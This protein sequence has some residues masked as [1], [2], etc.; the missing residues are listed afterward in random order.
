MQQK[1]AQEETE[2]QQLELQM[3]ETVMNE[4]FRLREIIAQEEGEDDDIRSVTSEQSSNSK[5]RQW[6]AFNSTMVASTEQAPPIDPTGNEATSAIGTTPVRHGSNQ[7]PPSNQGVLEDAMTGISLGQSGSEPTLGGI[8]GRTES[9]IVAT[10]G[11]NKTGLPPPPPAPSGT[12]FKTHLEQF[13]SHSLPTPPVPSVDIRV[14]FS[15]TSANVP[16]NNPAVVSQIANSCSRFAAQS[17]VLHEVGQT[18][19][20]RN[21]GMSVA[22]LLGGPPRLSFSA[23]PGPEQLGDQTVLQRGQLE[24]PYSSAIQPPLEHPPPHHGLAY[25]GPSPQQL[26]ARHVMAKELPTFSG[27]PEDWPL[28]ISAY[29]NS[30]QACGFTD[31]ENL[32]RLQRCLKGHALDSVRSRLLLPAGVPHVLA[33][34]ETLYGRPELLIHALLQKIRGVPPPKQDRLDT[35]IGFGMAVQNLSD[36][37][38]AGRH[39]AHLNNP[40]L[41]FELVEKLPA[42]MKLDWSL[43]KQR[44]AEVNIRSFAQYMQTL[45]RAATDVTLQYDPTQQLS[46]QLQRSSKERFGKDKNFCGTHTSENSTPISQAAEAVRGAS[47]SSNPTCLICKDPEHRVRDCSEFRK[48][49]VEERWKTIQQLSLCRLCLGA[50]GRRPCKIRK[51]CDIGGCQRRHHPLLHSDEEQ[52]DTRRAEDGK[53][54]KRDSKLPGNNVVANRNEV[55]QESAEPKPSDSKVSTNHHFA[56]KTTLFRIIPVTLHGNNRSVSVYAFLDDGS[57]KTLVD[58]EVVKQLGVIGESQPLCLQWTS[59]VKRTEAGS[60][61]VTLE[62]AGFSSSTKHTLSDVRTVNKLDLPRQ[63]LRYAE[64]VKTF[65][66]LRG[67]PVGDY[68]NAQPRILIGN[69]N[70]HVTSTLKLR[71]GQ[72]GEPIAAKSRLGWTVYGS[73][74]EKSVDRVHTFHLCECQ[75]TDQTLHERVEQFFSVDSLGIMEVDRPESVEIQRAN[76]ILRETTKRIGLRFETGLLWKYDCFE[77]PD[78]YHMAVRR[79]Q[80]LERRMQNDPVIGESVRRQLSEYQSKGYI[81]K[82]TQ[83]EL[84]DSDPRRTWYLPLGVVIN[85]KKP[86]KI[87]IFCDAAAKVDGISLN[88]MLLKGPD[89]LRTLLDVLFG[90]RERRIA[91]CAD[92]K[93]M[94]HQIRIRPEDRQAQRL[95]WREDPSQDPEVYLM[96]V[97]TFGATCSPCSAHFVKNLNAEEHAKEFPAAADAIIRKHYVDDYLDSADNVE[98]AVKLANEVKYVHSLGGFHLRNWLSNSREVLAR[99][100]ET[101]QAT[102]KCLQLEKSTTT[103]RVLGMYWKPDEDIFMFS[104]IPALNTKHPTKRQALRVVMSPFDPAGLLSFF[105][106]HGKILIQ[107]LWRAKTD[108][109]ELIPEKLC[110][111]WT[112]WIELFRNLED[113]RIPRCYFPYH[114]VNDIVSLQLHIYVDASEEAYACVGYLRAVFPD[115]IE[116]ALVGGKSKVAPLKAQSIPRLELMA[117]VIGVRFSQTILNG[118]SL[119]IEKVFFWS[120]S[121]TVLAWI[122]SDHRNY[123]QFVACRVGEIISKSN[124]E[125]WRW[126]STKKNVA[127][128]AT[129]W[130]KGPCL[131]SW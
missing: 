87:R 5:V 106:I 52:R 2:L 46:A 30:T 66:Y 104:T 33:T 118:H 114:S 57:E 113:I 84:D 17:S 43:Y 131:V 78:S 14:P 24:Q 93:E 109:D 8:I 80:C 101:D 126:I 108:W 64:L 73:N 35:L 107:D 18:S 82:A 74:Q 11:R 9:T 102:E 21:S 120:D 19:A 34:L 60:Q 92:L 81:H 31:A 116:V 7:R 69:D 55:S 95:I 47:R 61:R 112:R 85:P 38:E 68:E 96:D 39:E 117:A 122:N 28:F 29:A 50:H 3:E 99:V 45:V 119:K 76:R 71:D 6:R 115:G 123:R 53:H 26:A 48:K 15:Q 42:Q 100:G 62:I 1:K 22:D 75:E 91:P 36:H 23:Q 51:Q 129:K 83:K 98:E 111:K 63:T 37:L 77:F 44:C 12:S 70:A 49:A 40:M 13:S 65:P 27:N 79:L 88:T 41:L 128:E 4:S 124:P 86:S 25:G 56:G 105:L 89:F 90:F 110:E 67:L 58:E 20:N 103:E 130:G 72:P 32:A 16:V 54:G 59:N 94:F 97:A 10:A 125:Q 121:K 127:D